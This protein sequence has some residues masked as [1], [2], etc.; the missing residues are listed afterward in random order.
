MK[1]VYATSLRLKQFK[2][3][4]VKSKKVYDRKKKNKLPSFNG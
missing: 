4:I 1:N 2:N 3:K